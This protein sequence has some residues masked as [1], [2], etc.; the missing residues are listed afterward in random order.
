MA[1][2]E[3]PVMRRIQIDEEFR[4]YLCAASMQEYIDAALLL[5]DGV[6]NPCGLRRVG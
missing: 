3:R 5:Q 6:A 4:R 1:V 2:D